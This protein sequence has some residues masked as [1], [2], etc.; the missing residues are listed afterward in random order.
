MYLQKPLLDLLHAGKIPGESGMPEHIETVI[1][2]IYL[3][4]ERVYKVYRI[5]NDFFNNNYHDLAMREERLAFSKADFEWNRQLTKEMYIR[6]Q[7]VRVER[8]TIQ[9]VNELEDAEELLLVTKRLPANDSLFGRLQKKDLA[10]TDYYEI[11]KQFAEREKL[12]TVTDIP[13]ESIL[14]NM[15]GRHTDVIEW[16]KS[17]KNIP[18]SEGDNYLEILKKLI[19]DVYKDDSEKISFCIDSHSLNAFYTQGQLC[20]FDTFS[21]KDEWRY[22]PKLLNIYRLA[23]DVLALVGMKESCAVIKGYCEYLKAEI[24]SRKKDQLL[25]IYSALIMMPYLYMIGETDLDKREAAI[26][27]HDFLKLYISRILDV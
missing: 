6:L 12:M 15:L 9:S 16:I 21:P 23:T 18:S 10:E 19:T 22:G 1:S 17:N 14:D 24:P 27:Y 4:N 7:G 13:K 25:V 11:G 8:G 2:N 3:F 5:D 26:K 20:P